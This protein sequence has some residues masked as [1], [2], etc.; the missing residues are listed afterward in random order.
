MKN[1]DAESVPNCRC[2]DPTRVGEKSAAI[3]GFAE[4]AQVVSAIGDCSE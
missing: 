3:V 2:D 1:I 4:A